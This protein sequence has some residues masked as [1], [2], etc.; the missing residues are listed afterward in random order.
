MTDAQLFMAVS[1]AWFIGSFFMPDIFQRGLMAI[2]GIVIMIAS[3]G[4]SY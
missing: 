1:Q 4:L 2:T 3:I